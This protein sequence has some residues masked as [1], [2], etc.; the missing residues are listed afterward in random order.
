MNIIVNADEKVTNEAFKNNVEYIYKE[1]SEDEVSRCIIKGDMK[2]YPTGF[3][4]EFP[5]EIIELQ[6]TA[7]DLGRALAGWWGPEDSEFQ[8][9][10]GKNNKKCKVVNGCLLSS[11]GKTLYYYVGETMGH[12]RKLVIPKSVRTISPWAFAKTRIKEVV[13]GKNVENIGEYAFSDLGWF[14][15]FK[16]TVNK[17][18]KKIGKKAF[19][20]TEL[21]KVVFKRNVIMGQAA[22]HN[23][24]KI[25]YSKKDVR[26]WSTVLDKAYLKKD[27]LH[28]SF[29]KIAQAK[30]YQIRV[31]RGKKTYN[32]VTTKN[33]FSVVTP[34]D[35]KKNYKTKYT[36]N[37]FYENKNKIEGTPAYVT[38]RP[39]K[40]SKDK[41][42]I[43]GKWSSKMILTITGKNARWVL[44]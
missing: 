13:L 14:G 4:G 34:K 9:V 39:Y 22:F 8:I 5:P 20:K 26:K 2:G 6:G 40:L 29:C 11:D 17:K 30:G 19:Y 42:K 27:K 1:D 32:Y 15:D 33:D 28:I 23:D 37:W 10:I 3:F 38:V 21:A 7:D 12:D 36:Y 43:Y 16:L 44:W 41:K 25:Y 31:K 24:E 18:L 35:L